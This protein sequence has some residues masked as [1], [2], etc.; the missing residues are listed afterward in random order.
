VAARSRTEKSG[1]LSSDTN[2]RQ[3]AGWSISSN[4]NRRYVH[5]RGG[6]SMKDLLKVKG[7]S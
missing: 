3:F 6:E 7:I 5:L 1:L 4:M 2:L